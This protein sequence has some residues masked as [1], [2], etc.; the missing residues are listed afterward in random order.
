[1][2]VGKSGEVGRKGA[3]YDK[4]CGHRSI[5]WGLGELQPQPHQIASAPFLYEISQTE[6]YY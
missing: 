5:I 4:M 3:G 2:I 6:V 1:M